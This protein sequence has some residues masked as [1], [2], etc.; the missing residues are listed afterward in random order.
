MSILDYLLEDHATIPPDQGIFLDRTFRMHPDICRFISERIYEGRLAPS[1]E[2]EKRVFK[3]L[4]GLELPN[5]GIAYVPVMHEGNSQA[6]DEEVYV[7]KELTQNL[8]G[9]EIY[10]GDGRTKA[11]ALK[12]ILYVTPYN[13]QV[14]KLQEALGEEA[15]IGSVDRFQG[16]EAAVVILSMCA[17]NASSG[18]GVEFLFDKNRMNVALS[19]AQTLAIVVGHPDLATTFTTDIEKMAL[20]NLYGLLINYAKCVEIKPKTSKKEVG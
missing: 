12:D 14:R 8:L 19:R 9:Q 7:I 2:T 20:V 13:M 11:L 10:D 5:S 17:S 4:A 15:R 3:N 16:Q 1:S 18:R 6:S